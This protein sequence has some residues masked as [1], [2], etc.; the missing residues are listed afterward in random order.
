MNYETPTG[1]DCPGIEDEGDDAGA[2][3]EQI[4]SLL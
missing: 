3:A 1:N 4:R 2:I